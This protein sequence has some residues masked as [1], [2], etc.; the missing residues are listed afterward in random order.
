MYPDNRLD[1]AA[2]FLHMMFGNPCESDYGIADH[3]ARDGPHLPV[4]C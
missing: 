2:N 1:Y 4:T 3:R